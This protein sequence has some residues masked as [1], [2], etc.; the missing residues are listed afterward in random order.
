LPPALRE[1]GLRDAGDFVGVVLRA[2][3]E[4]GCA[5][6]GGIDAANSARIAGASSEKRESHD[7]YFSVSKMCGKAGEFQQI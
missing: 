4:I 1:L 2:R 6:G 5:D 3:L 7:I